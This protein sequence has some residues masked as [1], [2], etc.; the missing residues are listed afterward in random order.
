MIKIIK[1]VKIM[2]KCLQ[3]SKCVQMT[4]HIIHSQTDIKVI[5]DS[6]NLHTT[7]QMTIMVKSGKTKMLLKITKVKNSISGFSLCDGAAEIN[8]F[9]FSAVKKNSCWICSMLTLL[10]Y[11]FEIKDENKAEDKTFAE[12][13]YLTILWHQ[14]CNLK[15]HHSAFQSQLGRTQIHFFRKRMI[16]LKCTCSFPSP[17]QYKIIFE[18]RIWYLKQSAL[19]LR[20]PLTAYRQYTNCFWCK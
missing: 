2:I 15:M 4:L 1:I 9:T 13:N 5:N 14:K 16:L 18:C 17:R 12:L 7:Q 19:L 10:S 8:S 11:Q 3:H 20:K 6:Q